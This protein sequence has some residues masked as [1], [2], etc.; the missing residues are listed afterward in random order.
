[1]RF[2]EATALAGGY[3][4]RPCGLIAGHKYRF[5]GSDRVGRLTD[6]QASIH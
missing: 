4:R 5:Y 3:T 1:M 6:V 2:H